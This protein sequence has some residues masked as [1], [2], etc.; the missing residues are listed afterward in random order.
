MFAA[1]LALLVGSIAAAAALAASVGPQGTTAVESRVDA[2][3]GR[4]GTTMAEDNELSAR[5]QLH[6][7]RD[8]KLTH[9]TVSMPRGADTVLDLRFKR[10]ADGRVGTP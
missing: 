7:D 2:L 9:L 6:C 3:S 10:L 8:R 5:L 1:A 4:S